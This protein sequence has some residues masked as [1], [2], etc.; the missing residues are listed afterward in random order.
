MITSSVEVRHR[1]GVERVCW[2]RDESQTRKE[3]DGGGEG[4][5]TN[6][7]R[8][9]RDKGNRFVGSRNRTGFVKCYCYKC[10]P[11]YFIHISLI[12]TDTLSGKLEI[13]AT[14][15]HKKFNLR[16]PTKP[17]KL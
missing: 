14:Q 13:R 8:N 17:I 12:I 7:R 4:Q 2:T 10:L 11:I 15:I 9:N 3:V 1:T 16:G 6:E 5:N